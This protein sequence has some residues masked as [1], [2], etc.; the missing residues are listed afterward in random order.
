M[1]KYREGSPFVSAFRSS[2]ARPALTQASFSR[3]RH[4]PQPVASR[5]SWYVAPSGRVTRSTRSAAFEP[6]RSPSG[7]S[8]VFRST[9]AFGAL[10]A[11]G[12]RTGASAIAVSIAA[13]RLRDFFAGISS[14]T[15]AGDVST[16]SLCAAAI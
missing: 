16:G 10:G 3:G 8:V 9:G 4:S 2:S 11:F 14:T 1:A 15:T 12:S 6:T 13:R 5:S 7:R